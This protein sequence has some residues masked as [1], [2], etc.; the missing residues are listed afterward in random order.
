MAVR[1]HHRRRRDVAATTSRSTHC[2]CTTAR[3]WTTSWPPTSI[4]ARPASS[5]RGRIPSRAAHHRALQ[6]HQLLCSARRCGSRCCARRSST[7]VDLSSLRK[8]YYG[9]SA[10]PI[11]ILSE[12]RERLPQSEAVELL[13]PDR[14]GAPGLRTRTRRAGRTRRFGRTA[15]GQRGDDDPRR[16]D[17]PVAAGVVGE[18]AHRSPH[19]MPGYLDDP[20]RPPRLS[21]AAGSTPAI[22]AT[23]T[24]TACCTS[25]TARRT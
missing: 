5:F 21:R 4:W 20:D 2:R 6:R 15:G 22:S 14:D 10:M 12:M 16:R 3:S 11:E 23:T 18:I 19:L 1:Q 9:A 7:T 24:S 8:G 13:R 25:S 17:N